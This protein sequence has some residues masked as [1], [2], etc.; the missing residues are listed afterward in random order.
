MCEYCGCQAVE[1]IEVLTAEHDAVVNLIGTARTAAQQGD[2]AT[3]AA[4]ARD[5][6][7]VLAPHTVVEEEGLFPALAEESED[8]AGHIEQL[9][10]EHR[11]IEAVLAE[12]VDAPAPLGVPLDPA[13]PARLLDA[14]EL[15]RDHILKEQDGAFPAALATLGPDQWARVDAV[16]ARVVALWEAP[17]AARW[18]TTAAR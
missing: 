15:L 6:A 1:A 11:S 16:R 2:V 13:W 5:I 14:L 7:A 4:T 8:H 10:A 17:G 3:A 18:G 12:A 9:R